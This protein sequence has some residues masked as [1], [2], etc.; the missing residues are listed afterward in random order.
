MRSSK[1]LN[2]SEKEQILLLKC[3]GLNVLQTL[4]IQW[5]RDLFVHPSL[6]KNG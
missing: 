5:S 6:R 2:S 4:E 1:A 3:K